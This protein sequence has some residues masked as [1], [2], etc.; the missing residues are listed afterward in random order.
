MMLASDANN[1]DFMGA[2]NPDR[3]LSVQFYSKPIKNEFQSEQQQRPI[4]DAADMIKIITPGNTLSII[5]T[6]VRPEHKERFP[7]QWAAYKNRSDEHTHEMGTPITEWPRISATQAEEL[8]GLKFY[9]VEAIAGAA[10]AQLQGI[11]MIAGVSAYTFRDDA[12]RFLMVADAASKLSEA[13]KRV[14]DADDK[15][16]KMQADFAEQT[17][18]QNARIDAMLKAMEAKPD[19]PAPATQDDAKRGPGRPKQTEAA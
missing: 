3:R 10:D 12:K 16:A 13:D 11:G 7:G 19:A 14:K 18:A 1:P 15:I 4:F 9:T 17:A 8:R 6:F 2:H 5:D